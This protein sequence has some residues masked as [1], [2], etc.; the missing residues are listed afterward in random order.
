MNLEIFDPDAPVSPV[1]AKM[2]RTL[3]DMALAAGSTQDLVD[4]ILLP[5]VAITDAK[6]PGLDAIFGPTSTERMKLLIYRA[7]LLRE[8]SRAGLPL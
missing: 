7:E 3:G 8:R 5:L 1:A 4:A 6:S 2:S